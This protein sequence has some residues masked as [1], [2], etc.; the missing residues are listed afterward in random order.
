MRPARFALLAW[1]CVGC[2]VRVSADASGTSAKIPCDPSHPCATGSVCVNDQC[3]VSQLPISRVL[4]DI[5]LPASTA[6]DQYSGMSFVMALDVPTLGQADIILPVLGSL[7]IGAT[8]PN[9]SAA[10]RSCSYEIGSAD[11]ASARVEATHRWPVDGLERAVF[12]T[13]T[14]PAKLSGLPAGLN[15]ELYFTI[16][17]SDSDCQLP[18]VLV[19]DVNVAADRSLTLDWPTPTKS[20]VDVQLQSTNTQADTVLTGWQ[21]DVVDPVQGRTLANPI[22]L[23][24]ATTEAA[25][26]TIW[27]HRATLQ[28][29][30]IL[31]AESSP[32][33][34][35]ELIRLRP[36]VS[37]QQTQG[38]STADDAQ[39][40]ESAKPT[41]YASISSLKLF[42]G[43]SQLPLP[44][45]AVPA[46]VLISGRIETADSLQ[47]IQAWISFTST[48]FLASNSGIWASYATSARSDA[49]GQFKV[50]LPAGEYDVVVVPPG[51]GKHA[52]FDTHWTVPPTPSSQV[53]KVVQ[54][55]GYSQIRGSIDGSLVMSGSEAAT[56]TAT[57]AVSLV[58]DSASG[59]VASRVDSPGAR[60][61]STLFQPQA[62]REFSL[63]LDK[64]HFDL[65]LRPPDGL[66]WRVSPGH[67]ITAGRSELPKWAMPTPVSWAGTLQAPAKDSSANASSIAV[68]RAVLRIYALSDATGTAVSSPT[69][70]Q[71]IVQIAEGRTQADG[72]FELELPDRLQP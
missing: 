56:I 41:Y 11:V 50:A 61:A 55:P 48:G 72:S 6:T 58:Q 21:L 12:S 27:H 32:P 16:T 28:Y 40:L 45:N 53:D 18:P 42:A 34:G 36:P 46:P 19:R 24:A 1:L 17:S 65:S 15:Y 14:L 68:P 63:S 71:S 10:G 13:N 5:S 7:T 20:T 66:P 69:E 22:E 9:I 62:S 30:S 67:E 29:N 59:V 52:V 57:P 4:A 64:G 39:L 33:V 35:T 8:F 43:N 26:P 37:S 60:T 2:T 70:A 44:I 25:D 31:S 54:I 3:R 47:P 23:P 51:D 49:N 38:S